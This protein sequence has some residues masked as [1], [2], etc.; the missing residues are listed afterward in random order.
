M[1]ID[2]PQ[3]IYLAINIL[4]MGIL[5]AEHGKP[6]AGKENCL[7]GIIGGAICLALL[8]WGG[9]FAPPQ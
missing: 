2:W 3:G 8:Y 9:F 7:P 4:S 6:R 5:I 1:Y